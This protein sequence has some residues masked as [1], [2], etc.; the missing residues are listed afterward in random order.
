[1]GNGGSRGA[2]VPRRDAAGD[3]SAVEGGAAIH[4]N[5]LWERGQ[6]V[7]VDPC[8]HRCRLRDVA[9]PEADRSIPRSDAGG[10]RVGQ[11]PGDRSGGRRRAASARRAC[12]HELRAPEADRRRRCAGRDNHRSNDCREDLPRHEAAV[13]RGVDRPQRCGRR[14]RPRVR[15]R[16]HELDVMEEPDGPAPVGDQSALRLGADVRH[17]SHG[18]RAPGSIQ[19]RSQHPR[20]PHAGDLGASQETRPG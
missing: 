18:R 15:V 9:D 7:R 2:A 19:R 10:H 16:V 12:V 17:R 11:L 4:G 3:E 6:H 8:H 1:M 5:I 13:A 14:M 20:R